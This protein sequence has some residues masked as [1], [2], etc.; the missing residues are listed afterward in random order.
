MYKHLKKY[1][2]EIL[3]LSN[4]DKNHEMQYLTNKGTLEIEKMSTA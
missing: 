2:H 4:Y 1:F 3:D